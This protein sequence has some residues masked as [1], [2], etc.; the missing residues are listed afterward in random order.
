MDKNELL[1]L[2]PVVSVNNSIK[3]ISQRLPELLLRYDKGDTY[4]E[5]FRRVMIKRIGGVTGELEGIKSWAKDTVDKDLEEIKNIRN[6]LKKNKKKINEKS[7]EVYDN[8]KKDAEII[9]EGTALEIKYMY[10]KASEGDIEIPF[11]DAGII[12]NAQR[13][14]DTFDIK[15]ARNAKR[16][17]FKMAKEIVS[18]KNETSGTKAEID[19]NVETGANTSAYFGATLGTRL[20]MFK[21]TSKKNYR[22]LYLIIIGIAI[23]FIL[24][25]VNNYF[26]NKT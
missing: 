26:N 25:Q 21:N 8:A 4:N 15:E 9:K 22:Y 6:N 24:L 17:A 16:R 19:T 23:Y 7:K 14:I 20:E 18:Q 11:K 5:F 1:K 3:F 13:L 10:L 12:K 2:P